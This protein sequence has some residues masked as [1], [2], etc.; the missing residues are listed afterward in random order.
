VTHRQRL[1]P[2]ALVLL[3]ACPQA[4]P[5]APTPTA[6]G[7]HPAPDDPR[8]VA[9]TGDLYAAQSA[10]SAL[11]PPEG[12]KPDKAPGSGRPDETNGVCRLYA[13]QLAE[14][15]CCE[16]TLGFDSTFAADTCG[17][18]VYLGESFHNT[19]GF[20]FVPQPNTP[21][22]WFRIALIMG[23]TPLQ[24]AE[25]NLKQMR[26]HDPTV[27]VEP[28]P[29]VPGAYWTKQKEYR[30]AF[31]PGWS[32]VRMF[33]WKTDTCSDDKIGGVLRHIIAAP[34]NVAGPRRNGLFP[35]AAPPVAAPK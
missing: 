5:P 29:D 31:L 32:A 12:E 6:D 13:P 1:A 25:D 24:A 34:E 10:P 14:P 22:Q 35:A 19:C 11:R 17:L 4:Q 27:A 21:A 15:K 33:A 8:V 26:R 16:H 30:W 7:A 28:V 9:E 2:F 18:Q 20:Y 23:D 3:A